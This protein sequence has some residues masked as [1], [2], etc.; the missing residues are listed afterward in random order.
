MMKLDLTFSFEGTKV[1]CDFNL[2][3]VKK[4]FYWD[5]PEPVRP[6]A[7]T[8]RWLGL[9][10]IYPVY[11]L[12]RDEC[13]VVDLKG[14]HPGRSEIN[15][16]WNAVLNERRN[17]YASKF[18]GGD[19]PHTELALVVEFSP[20]WSPCPSVPGRS[21]QFFSYGKE[22]QLTRMLA[23][24]IMPLDEHHLAFT[25]VMNLNR[26]AYL[27][28][29]EKY[30]NEYLRMVK[31]NQNHL[32]G[33][34]H[35]MFPEQWEAAKKHPEKGD[36]IDFMH[37]PVWLPYIVTHGIT[38]W[39]AGN[40]YDCTQRKVT[41]DGKGFH[42]GYPIFYESIYYE[43]LFNTMME[44]TIENGC[45]FSP[46]SPL[47]EP[48]IIKT[49]KENW[50][51][52]DKDIMACWHVGPKTRWCGRCEKCCRYYATDL[53]LG[54]EPRLKLKNKWHK[55]WPKVSREASDGIYNE[56]SFMIHASRFETMP[57]W[58]ADTLCDF[59]SSLPDIWTTADP[60]PKHGEDFT[61]DA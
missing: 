58:A 5:Y 18:Y 43:W 36:R 38:T 42:Y 44:Q 51:E 59:Y 40:E 47:L 17:S 45:Y 10:M 53:I 50:P 29:A 7:C 19:N 30:D 24:H 46:V 3:G 28:E 9:N 32:S 20:E 35:K 23:T 33:I 56:R 11:G 21:G 2:D 48:L 8:A 15:T 25:D 49:L 6:D 54:A 12:C 4:K 31:T 34:L 22:S 39:Y 52:A 57:E 55:L 13:L 27:R 37:L 16:I 14:I 61:F 41:E 60:N 1:L 26:P